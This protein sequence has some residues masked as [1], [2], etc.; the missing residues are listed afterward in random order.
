MGRQSLVFVRDLDQ[1]ILGSDAQY[2]N[3]SKQQKVDH[4]KMLKKGTDMVVNA[5]LLLRRL[6]K[7]KRSSTLEGFGASLLP[8][9]TRFLP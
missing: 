1:S 7:Q 8:A 2:Q 3:L 6:I 9:Q 4:F 5:I